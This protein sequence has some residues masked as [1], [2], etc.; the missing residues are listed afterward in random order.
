MAA[1]TKQGDQEIK[2]MRRSIGGLL[3]TAV[4]TM[5][6]LGTATFAQQQGEK[7]K[8]GY[9]PDA[10]Q[11]LSGG[12]D[13]TGFPLKEPPPDVVAAQKKAP[14]PKMSDGHPDL[15]GFWGTAGWGYAVTYGKLS[16]DGKTYDIENP[17]GLADRPSAIAAAKAYREAHPANS[18]PYKP[19]YAEKAKELTDHFMKFDPVFYCSAP[20]FPRLGPPT[21]IVEKPDVLVFL[22]DLAEQPNAFR[23]IPTD[24]RSHNTTLNPTLLGDSIGHWEGDTMV[25]D[26]NDFDDSTWISR[27]APIH[28]D[29]MHVVETLHREGNTIHW[30]LK[31]ED[32]KVFTKAWEIDRTL[33]VGLKGGHVLEEEPCKERDAVHVPNK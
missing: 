8:R 4:A 5:V 22:Y 19:E 17:V 21:E 25:I 12:N 10:D 6:W 15:T 26:V 13:G 16:A 11:T 1:R 2:Q 27:Q 30:H 23:L 31:V 33:I 28:S 29:E 20:G 3:A 32:P 7:V 14:T 24:G 9:G 18:P